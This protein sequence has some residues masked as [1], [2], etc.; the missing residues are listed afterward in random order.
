MQQLHVLGM[1][2]VAVICKCCSQGVHNVRQ[3]PI[4][5]GAMARLLS[6]REQAALFVRVSAIAPVWS[7]LCGTMSEHVVSLRVHL[8]QAD[9]CICKDCASASARRDAC[10]SFLTASLIKRASSTVLLDNA[11][12]EPAA[13]L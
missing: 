12:P 7:A 11:T 2:S 13:P 9:S 8:A 3:F 4:V 6:L 10:S 5:K 1:Y